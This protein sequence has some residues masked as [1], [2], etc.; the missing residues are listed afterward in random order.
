MARVC[1]HHP[2]LLSEN[3]CGRCGAEFCAECL[4]HPRGQ[5]LPLCV[6]CAVAAGGAN[7]GTKGLSRRKIRSIAR[8]RA[9]EVS[10]AAPPPLPVIENPVPTG[11]A[12]GEAEEI[13]RPAVPPPEATKRG[14]RRRNRDLAPRAAAPEGPRDDMMSWLDSV[15]A[16]EPTE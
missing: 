3:I 9:A 16:T 11:F 5:K 10:A 12:F 4:V 2:F 6:T 13:T 14:G 1:N 8:T 15:Y 7:P